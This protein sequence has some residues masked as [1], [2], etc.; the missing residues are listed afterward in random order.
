MSETLGVVGKLVGKSCHGFSLVYIG[1]P[2][3][4]CEC[5]DFRINGIV[6]QQLWPYI[7]VYSL[8]C[9]TKKSE[10]DFILS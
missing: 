9:K 8:Y 2:I 6:L 5:K 3:A 4:M 1:F 7:P 10:R